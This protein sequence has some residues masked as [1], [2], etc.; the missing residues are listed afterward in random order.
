VSFQHYDHWDAYD[1][2]TPL[3]FDYPSATDETIG[4]QSADP[5]F[6]QRLELIRADFESLP[7]HDQRR[8]QRRRLDGLDAQQERTNAGE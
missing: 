1:G 7:G 6:I 8:R 4:I 5:L 3:R 2:Q